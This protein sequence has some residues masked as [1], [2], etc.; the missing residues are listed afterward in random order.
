MVCG[1][2]ILEPLSE[3][4]AISLDGLGVDAAVQRLAA[5]YQNAAECM[6]IPDVA[7]ALRRLVRRCL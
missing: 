4:E 2:M 7:R 1:V 5:F 3:I 6:S